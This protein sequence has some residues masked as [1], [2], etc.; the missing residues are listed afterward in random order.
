MSA[1]NSIY[2]VITDFNGW[3]Q[4]RTC[5]QKLNESSCKDFRT[6]VVDH[7]TSGETAAGI[8]EFPSCI[9]VRGGPEVWWTGATNLGIREA[10]ARDATHVMLLN[11]DCYVGQSTLATLVDHVAAKHD[12]IVAPVQRDLAS[13]DVFVVRMGTCIPLGFATV[14]TA[15]M[16]KL[17][18]SGDRLLRTE[19][20]AGG[21]GALIPVQVFDRVGLPDE[22]ALPHYYA[23]HDFYLR[24]RAHGVQ[25]YV[26]TDANV[27]ID[28]TRTTIARDPGAMNW[29]QFRQSFNDR[30]SHRNLDALKALFSRHYPVRT[31][32]PIGMFLNVSRYSLSYIVRRATRF[33][34][35]SA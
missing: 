31:L 23:D 4:T 32:Y 2:V 5:L 16:R 15:R 9:H 14:V 8:A 33:L 35:R 34:R 28:D 7:G 19:I 10:L 17:P 30:R 27:Y 21:R 22:E 13:G 11:N 18:T 20:I 6:I 25:L 1:G 24:C 3:Q 12:M 29:A 26:A